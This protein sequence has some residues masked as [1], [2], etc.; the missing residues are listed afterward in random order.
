MLEQRHNRTH[1]GLQQINVTTPPEEFYLRASWV[2]RDDHAEASRKAHAAAKAAQQ[3]AAAAGLVP[4]FPLGSPSAAPQVRKPAVKTN[5]GY[6]LMK[7]TPLGLINQD[8]Q[9][10]RSKMTKP[11]VVAPLSDS[12]DSDR[13]EDDASDGEHESKTNVKPSNR[14]FSSPKSVPT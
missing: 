2:E 11:L 9:W 14:S 13:G 8:S 1:S 5:E 10:A 6:K 4:S 7:R 3:E 12:S